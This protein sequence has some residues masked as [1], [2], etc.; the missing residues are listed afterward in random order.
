MSLLGDRHDRKCRIAVVFFRREE[1][2][3]WSAIGL[4]L[5]LIL[6]FVVLIPI[7][8]GVYVY[9]DA[10]AR[11]MDAVLWTIIAVIAPGL[12]GFIVYLIVRNGES[13]SLLPAVRCGGNGAIP[14]LSAMRSGLKR[15]CPARRCCRGKVAG[16]PVLRCAAPSRAGS[17]C[18]AAKKKGPCVAYGDPLRDLFFPVA[19]RAVF[20][21]CF[22]ELWWYGA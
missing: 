9:R 5:P 8:V 12:I 1:G 16:M 21:V 11:R 13:W 20:D 17:A 3:K 10:K 18:C 2:W 7:L 19:M 15:R 6:V 4:L 14:C 22:A